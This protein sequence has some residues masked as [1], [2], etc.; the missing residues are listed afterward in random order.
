MKKTTIITNIFIV[1]TFVIVLFVK[2]D[3]NKFNSIFFTNNN[4]NYYFTLSTSNGN[5]NDINEKNFLILT[6]YNKNNNNKKEIFNLKD[7]N[8]DNN[9]SIYI[10][11]AKSNNNFI[12]I[13]DLI[14]EEIISI[15]I[16]NK[17]T[18]LL[19]SGVENSN[20]L[21]AIKDF[22]VTD[23]KLIYSGIDKEGSFINILDLNTNKSTNIFKSNIRAEIPVTIDLNKAA[24]L[25][26]N[27]IYLYSIDNN[28]IL[29][30]T[31]PLYKDNL[32]LYKNTIYTI[33]N[34]DENLKTFVSLPLDFNNNL[35][36]E[37][38][39]L[40]Y[41]NKTSDIYRYNDNIVIENYFF[42]T[43]SQKLYTTILNNKSQPYNTTIIGD[44]IISKKGKFKKLEY[45]KNYKEYNLDFDINYAP[46]TLDIDEDRTIKVS[47]DGAVVVLK[48]GT[49]EIIDSFNG[50]MPKTPS[51]LLRDF[52]YKDNH[53][54]GIVEQKNSP[55]QIISLNIKTGNLRVIKQIL[56][57]MDNILQF[58]IFND[59]IG[60]LSYSD[61]NYIA[62]IY[63]NSEH[64]YY[65]Y[66]LNCSDTINEML[67]ND[68][69]IVYQS[70][71]NLSIINTSTGESKN[72]KPEVNYNLYN[73]TS[74]SIVMKS[75]NKFIIMDFNFN[76]IKTFSNSNK[77]NNH[78]NKNK[79]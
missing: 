43:K 66:K 44:Y 1:I 29:N 50:F 40:K 39:I 4:S 65:N 41:V 24:F 28:K 61:N 27:K 59:T 48:K 64:K 31:A 73:I 72:F 68:K 14:S 19:L 77:L 8:K 30:E 36:I 45:D 47:Y 56:K 6:T 76:K 55:P 35:S 9:K 23:N 52:Y 71:N 58:Y 16:N 60:Y 33:K 34:T 69:Y 49:N 13:H 70:Y 25:F 22:E 75:N 18:Q 12:F 32:L 2:Y 63:N 26:E 3:S 37:K 53:L 5:T 20:N 67:F 62:S 21:F 78:L 7:L 38:P 51:L 79:D 46:N 15:N 57:N 11:T 10:T 54:Y 17:K 42:N 74:D